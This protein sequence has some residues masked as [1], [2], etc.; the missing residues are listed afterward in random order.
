[1]MNLRPETK[2]DPSILFPISMFRL[3]LTCPHTN[4]PQYYSQVYYTDAKTEVNRLN[5]L[6]KRAYLDRSV[7]IHY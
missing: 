2:S 7:M 5:Y 3:L 1:M 4:G 6:L